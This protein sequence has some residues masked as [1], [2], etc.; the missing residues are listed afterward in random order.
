[1]S[2]YVPVLG[3]KNCENVELL[4]AICYAIRSHKMQKFLELCNPSDSTLRV[5][6]RS[7][8]SPAELRVCLKRCFKNLLERPVQA[9][10]SVV[11]ESGVRNLQQ[12]CVH[13]LKDAFKI[14]LSILC[15]LWYLSYP[16]AECGI[17]QRY[18]SVR[19]RSTSLSTSSQ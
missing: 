17:K 19:S 16:K 11:S 10:V 7:A 1:V 9:L 6:K 5:R 4:P 14:C 13:A 8:E 18:V 3:K 15:K 12:K 2:D